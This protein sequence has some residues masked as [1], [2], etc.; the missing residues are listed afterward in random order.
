MTL[1]FQFFLCISASRKLKTFRAQFWELSARLPGSTATCHASQTAVEVAN[2][3]FA[4][5]QAKKLSP[6]RVPSAAM[7]A[8]TFCILSRVQ[9]RCLF[10]RLH[11]LQSQPVTMDNA[12]C[13][14]RLQA[15]QQLG[16]WSDLGFQGNDP[17]TD[18]RGSGR[19]ALEC[20]HVLCQGAPDVILR[21]LQQS[22][23]GHA[24]YPF[25]CAVINVVHF[26]IVALRHGH[27]DAA[28][29]S[30]GYEPAVF[31]NTVAHAVCRC[32]KACCSFIVNAR[33]HVCSTARQRV[34]FSSRLLL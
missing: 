27:L 8:L 9:L 15:L 34:C 1:S 29:R 28:M 12:W 13:A 20:L 32:T 25:A 33:F 17:C 4:L 19:L 24:A 30:G 31:H 18:F 16:S 23:D 5:L 7:S 26:S 2:A 11:E 22:R 10:A 6:E 21:L 3:K 14:L